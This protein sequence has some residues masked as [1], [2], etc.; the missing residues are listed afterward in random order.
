MCCHI[1]KCGRFCRLFKNPI[2]RNFTNLFI[3]LLQTI[4]IDILSLNL[5]V[6][7]IM[8]KITCYPQKKQM[9]IHKYY[10]NSILQK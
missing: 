6:I 3:K 2:K 10:Y 7:V 5:V 1:K 4:F 9:H 8:I